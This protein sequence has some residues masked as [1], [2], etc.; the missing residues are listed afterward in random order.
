MRYG[1]FVIMLYIKNRGYYNKALENIDKG[2]MFFD[3]LYFIYW[4][5]IDGYV[6]FVD[7]V[8]VR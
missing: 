3:V 1:E 8:I 4:F 6:Y 5:V 7:N 2:D